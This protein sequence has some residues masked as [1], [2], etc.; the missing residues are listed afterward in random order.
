MYFV[1]SGLYRF[2]S[3]RERWGLV[4]SDRRVYIASSVRIRRSKQ[5]R[6]ELMDG[7]VIDDY[8]VL[9]C[10]VDPLGVELS[11]P[12]TLEVGARSYIGQGNN[13]RAGGG[14]IKIGADCLISQHVTIVASN[15]GTAK[16]LPIAHQ[17]WCNNRIGVQISDDVWIGAGA[18]ILPGVK[19]GRGAVVAA[20]A[21]VHRDVADYSIVGGIPARVLKE[22]V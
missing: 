10:T 6:I 7:V 18:V 2:L 14:N 16:N 15:H 22:R 11:P 21:V 12:S 20:N 3:A 19:I 13:I 4:F 17:R 8:T 1:R 5:C 9:E